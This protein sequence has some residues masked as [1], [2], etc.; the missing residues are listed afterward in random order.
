MSLRFRLIGLVCV[1]L[2]ISLALAGMTAYSNASRSV[3]TEMR[4]AFLVGRQTIASAIDRLQNAR[5]PVRDLDDLVVSFRGNRHLRIRHAGETPALRR[6]L[7]KEIGIRPPVGM[8]RAPRRSFAR[9]PANPY[10]GG[11]SRLGHDRDRDAPYNETLEV[12]HAL[13]ESL[14]QFIGRLH[15]YTRMRMITP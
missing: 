1:V 13:A 2:L 10:C 8:V 6:T 9:D 4:A 3:R 5:D 15:K 14:A 12:R 7:H 11:R